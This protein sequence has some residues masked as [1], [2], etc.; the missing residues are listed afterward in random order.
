VFRILSRYVFREILTSSVLGTLLATFVVF[1]QKIDR[2]FEVLVGAN[3]NFKT[4]VTLFALTLPPVLPLTIPFGV[5]VGIL[6]GLG[7]MSSDGEITAMRAAGVS[8]RRVIAPVLAFAA[9]G[10]ALAGYASLRLTPYSLR[11]STEILNQLLAN[12]ITA[13]IQPRIFDE[14]FPNTILY[15]GD[16][17]PGAPVV[18]RPVFLADVSDPDKRKSGL[19]QKADGPLI[20]V[21][22]LAL[23]TSDTKNNRIQLQMRDYSTH[24]MGKDGVARDD[25]APVK[26]IAL[27]LKP[28]EQRSLASS[29]MSTSQLIHYRGPDWIEVGVELHRRFS[30]PLACLAL[31][32]VGIP[33]GISTRKGGKSAGYVNAIFLAFFGYYLSSVSLVGV[34]K[35]RT[36]PIPVA[37]WL[38][39]VVFGVAGV[40]FLV[41]ME[42]PGDR[43]L[44]S[45]LREAF[46]HLFQ[47]LRRA[48]SRKSE[49]GWFKGWRLPLLPQI[50]DTYILSNFL[51]YMVV[52]L[53]SFVSM[54][55]VYNF[56]ELMGD[57]LRNSSL[58]TM[59]TYLFFLIPLQIYKLLPISVLVAVLVTLGVLSKQNEVTAFKA[60]GVSLYRMAAPILIVSTLFAG[61]LFG[62]DFS[63]VPSANRRQDALRDEIKGRPQQTYLNPNR[64]W[65][66]GRDSRIYYYK[67]F[68]PGEKVMVEVSVFELDPNSFRLAR[69][70][71]AKRAFWSAPVN[72]W[73]FEDGWSSDFRGPQRVPPLHTFQATTFPELT[74]AP[75][76]F[77]REAVQEKQMNFLELE[78]Y[79]ADL[80]Q[81]GLVDTRKLQVQYYLKFA[82]PLFAII[83]AMLAVP[84][85]FLVGNRGAMTGIG[86]SIVIAI[87]YL[88]LQ[89]LFEKIG[90]VGLLP[91]A[92][93]AWSP[94]VVFAL[95]GMY[96]LLRMRS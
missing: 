77:L 30:L 75:D 59:F 62:F 5:L 24:E 33:L 80:Q 84:F 7:R 36:L 32:L 49:P 19:G 94:D 47:R 87:A 96:L 38:P 79:I 89:P 76:Y 39:D 67:Y 11:K 63:Y 53:A 34:A 72:A 73:I 71:Q 90:D 83:M 10:T 9:L 46:G 16:V 1:L 43:D 45:G 3:P 74:E 88:G 60:C 78:R 14:D 31:A 70:I 92:M 21:A 18:W 2:L 52:V 48:P 82:N 25:S 95:V 13:E 56:F 23:A 93:A 41:R 91:P 29:A 4:V 54:A 26:T 61:G 57:M 40:L 55:E 86:A 50:I 44:I 27:D 42:L 37:T 64:K 65:I 22:R 8:S 20:T 81:T 58:M 69:Q 6:I 51:F 17:R 15:V 66:M 85:G 28:P 35:Q 12:Q 68:D